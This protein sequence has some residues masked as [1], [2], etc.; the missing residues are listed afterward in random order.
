[1]VYHIFFYATQD[2]PWICTF[3]ANSIN[4]MNILTEGEKITCSIPYA[5]VKQLTVA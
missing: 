2:K 3:N 5:G 1:M 4:Q